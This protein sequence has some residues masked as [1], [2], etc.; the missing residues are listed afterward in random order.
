MC[1]TVMREISGNASKSVGRLSEN[2]SFKYT[3]S[4]NSLLL[5]LSHCQYFSV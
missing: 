4:D 3:L 2:I 1:G 5:S